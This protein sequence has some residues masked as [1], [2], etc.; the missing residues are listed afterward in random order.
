MKAQKTSPDKIPKIHVTKERETAN[1]IAKK[2]GVTFEDLKQWNSDLFAK[3]TATKTDKKTNTV[4]SDTKLWAG[5]TLNLSAPRLY[6]R[7]NPAVV[8]DTSTPPIN[9]LPPPIGISELVGQDTDT[10]I[11]QAE[12]VMAYHLSGRK[13]DSTG[14]IGFKLIAEKAL[15]QAQVTKLKTMV[16]DTSS[17]FVTKWMKRCGFAPALYFSFK[18]GDQKTGFGFDLDCDVSKVFKAGESEQT[19][20]NVDP[21]GKDLLKF[22]KEIFP[23]STY[24]TQRLQDIATQQQATSS[25]N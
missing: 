10:L 19:T 3:R 25:Q 9:D 14:I 23:N 2:Y 1:G 17:Y 5:D 24:F 20:L 4:S 13:Y 12:E 18:K 7:D 6:S 21:I 16:R 8:S 11:S 15:T 22:G